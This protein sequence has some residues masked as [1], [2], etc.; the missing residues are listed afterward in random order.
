M[1]IVPKF[2][3][4]AIVA[5]NYEE[6]MRADNRRERY[7]L[8]YQSLPQAHGN[9]SSAVIPIAFHSILNYIVIIQ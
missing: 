3:D 8:E 9:V 6:E 4:N 2:Y 1:F 5:D 7:F